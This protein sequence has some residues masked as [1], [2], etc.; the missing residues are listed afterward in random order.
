MLR[1][2]DLDGWLYFARGLARQGYT[3]YQI[4]YGVDCPEGLI[5]RFMTLDDRPNIEVVTQDRD[6]AAAILAYKPK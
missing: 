6:V 4:Q 3:L 1:L 2:Y 5:A